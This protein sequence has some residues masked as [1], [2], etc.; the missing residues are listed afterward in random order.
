[1]QLANR[2]GVW[3]HRTLADIYKA[4]SGKTDTYRKAGFTSAL[5]T[6]YPSI[7]AGKGDIL[8][9]SG[10]PLRAATVESEVVQLVSLGRRRPGASFRERR[11]PGSVMG[12]VALLRQ[13]FLDAEWRASQRDAVRGTPEPGRTAPARPRARSYRRDD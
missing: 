3:P 7:L 8:Q 6:P 2:R 9:L 4:D 13:T 12:A 11:Y 1:M 10:A 5:V